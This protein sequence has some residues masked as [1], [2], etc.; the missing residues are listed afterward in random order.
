MRRWLRSA[1]RRTRRNESGGATPT[2][3][4]HC[5]HAAAQPGHLRVVG[6]PITLGIKLV[7]QIIINDF[8]KQY[9]LFEC[10]H[11]RTPSPPLSSRSR[12][13]R[14][15]QHL[16][17]DGLTGR[18]AGTA[19]ASYDSLRLRV[20]A[21]TKED[22]RAGTTD[23]LPAA[24]PNVTMPRRSP[25]TAPDHRS[26][27]GAEPLRPFRAG[28]PSR[29]WTHMLTKLLRRPVADPSRDALNVRSQDP[30]SPKASGTW[31]SHR[32]EAAVLF[33]FRIGARET[34]PSYGK[35]A[36]RQASN[37]SRHAHA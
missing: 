25:S 28:R 24:A 15:A 36:A 30:A 8:L 17:G 7:T 20:D 3:G 9:Q 11:G 5:R 35:R 13:F 26:A 10:N 33:R 29:R 12:Q 27:I 6:H 16:R 37:V 34:S 23:M 18:Q 22:A 1:N 4:T 2:A 31:I 32:P 14:L 21:T 19:P